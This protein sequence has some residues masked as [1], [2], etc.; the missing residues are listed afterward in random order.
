MIPAIRVDKLAKRYK[1]GRHQRRPYRTFREAITDAASARWQ[2]LRRL[3]RLSGSARASRQL[4]QDRSEQFWALQD[5]SFNIAPGEV[6]GIVGRNGAGKST[7]LKI[8]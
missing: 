4:G 8:L 1:L 3:F 6:V 2:D 7:L 5:V